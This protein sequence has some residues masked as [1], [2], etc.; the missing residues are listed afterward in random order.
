MY[1]TEAIEKAKRLHPFE[2]GVAE[3][4][5]WCNELSGELAKNYECNLISITLTGENEILLP[6]DTG[7]CDIV[8]IYVDGKVANKTDLTDF[9]Y[10]V[11]HSEYGDYFRKKPSA[12]Y[13][14]EIILRAPHSP[15]RMLDC[16]T[17]AVVSGNTI[18]CG[19]NLQIGDTIYITF[20]E[21]NHKIIIVGANEN[22]FKFEGEAGFVG[23]KNIHIEREITEKTLLPPPYDTA[24]IDFVCAKAALYQ[25]DSET[26]DT[27]YA[28]YAQKL[29]NY[30]CYLS[31]NMPRPRAKITNWW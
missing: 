28:Q 26:Y 30:R 22:G 23:E 29:G 20:G 3:C 5:D 9:A 27:F 17:I 15:I 1:I 7:I 14:I 24:Y 8:R 13:N 6:P 2:Y 18:K 21:E 10:V 12:P 4:I 19:E 11:H 25:G 31:R 16:D